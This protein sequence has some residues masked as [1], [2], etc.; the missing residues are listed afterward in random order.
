MKKYRRLLCFLFTENT[1]IWNS[2]AEYI[3]DDYDDDAD[4]GDDDDGA[5]GQNII[6][7]EITLLSRD[8]PRLSVETLWEHEKV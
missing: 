3:T 6:S 2:I 4:D 7:S 8:F 5:E 1:L